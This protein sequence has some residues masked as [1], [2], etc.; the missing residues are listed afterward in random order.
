MTHENAIKWIKV[1]SN[2]INFK[3]TES[4]TVNDIYSDAFILTYENGK[5]L[6]YNITRALWKEKY[7]NISKAQSG[8]CVDRDYEKKC[9]RCKVT[10]NQAEFDLRYKPEFKI[11][12]LN[13]ICKVCRIIYNKEFYKRKYATD[14]DYKH[15][16]IERAHEYRNKPENKVKENQRRAERRLNDPDYKKKRNEYVKQKR[17]ENPEHFKKLARESYHRNKHKRNANNITIKKDSL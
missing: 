7:E 1:Y 14:E 12:Y 16:A 2:K 17:K 6:A 3:F 15:K 9:N 5:S 8:K 10:K 4:V 11:Y 13:H